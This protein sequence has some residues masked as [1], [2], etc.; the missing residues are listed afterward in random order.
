[1]FSGRPILHFYSW[2]RRCQRPLAIERT[3]TARAAV[4]VSIT[5]SAERSEHDGMVPVKGG[6]CARANQ[7]PGPWRTLFP[8]L[9]HF[10][11]SKC[12]NPRGCCVFHLFRSVRR[13]PG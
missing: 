6:L 1:M 4:A 8:V 3:R 9:P 2:R 5:A 10:D 11:P 12:Q 13:I 7:S